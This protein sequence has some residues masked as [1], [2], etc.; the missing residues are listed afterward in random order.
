M[1]YAIACVQAY[2]RHPRTA[3]YFLQMHPRRH[4]N[5]NNAVIYNLLCPGCIMRRLLDRLW[6]RDQTVPGSLPANGSLDQW[7]TLQ[8]TRLHGATRVLLRIMQTTRECVS[9]VR[10]AF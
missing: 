9:P 5:N 10:L 4:P 2:L 8:Q 1:R 3:A 6:V 7:R